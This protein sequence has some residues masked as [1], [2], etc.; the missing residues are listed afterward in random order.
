MLCFKIYCVFLK[1]EFFTQYIMFLKRLFASF[2][3]SF[4]FLFS[5]SQN[6]IQYITTAQLDS[7]YNI[8]QSKV[9]SISNFEIDRLG[10]NDC[11]LNDVETHLNLLQYYGIERFFDF[12]NLSQIE[13]Y[14]KYKNLITEVKQIRTVL[15]QQIANIDFWY[16]K[17]AK[18]YLSKSD[19]LNALLFLDKSLLYN[20]LF[21]FSVNLK[22]NLLI[23]QNKC[24]EASIDLIKISGLIYPD[25]DFYKLLYTTVLQLN[26]AL[27]EKSEMYYKT[28]YYNE[29]MLY[30]QYADSLCKSFGFYNCKD[31]TNGILNSKKGIYNSYLRIANQAIAT[32]N[33]SIAES[34]TDKALEYADINRDAI[35]NNEETNQNYR[36][37]V[38][39]YLSF[40]AKY[41]QNN[42][43]KSADYYLQKA[44]RIC[45]LL[46][47]TDCK[48][49]KIDIA[50]NILLPDTVLSEAENKHVSDIQTV[51]KEN[52]KEIKR[53]IKKR[54]KSINEKQITNIK[55]QQNLNNVRNSIALEMIEI[56]NELYSKSKF[57]EA[58]QKFSSAKTLLATAKST[59]KVKIDNLI[60]QTAE[61]I[62]ILPLKDINFAIW[63]DDFEKVDSLIKICKKLQLDYNLIDNTF[64]ND[65]LKRINDEKY[66]KICK[67]TEEKL[68][69]L[70][71]KAFSLF[72][73]KEFQKVQIIVD[74]MELIKSKSNYCSIKDGDI[75][76]I[77]ALIKPVTSYFNL[78]NEAKQS[79][80]EKKYPIFINLYNS[81]DSVY[82]L[83][84]LDSLKIAENNIIS[85]LKYQNND[86]ANMQVAEI[87]LLKG[88][89]NECFQL[90][91]VL[92]ENNYDAIQTKKI[93]EDLVELVASNKQLDLVYLNI[94]FPFLNDEK[95]FRYFVRKTKLFKKK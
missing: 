23:S 34:F 38:N 89:Q 91:N 11:E 35:S 9:K 17:T 14:Q 68:G 32:N 93:Q 55:K 26:S 20:N 84:Q 69:L 71:G 2:V 67:N 66:H 28:G 62:V 72:E 77:S 65:E 18:D 87:L 42:N 45:E 1:I 46:N 82:K 59:D 15:D 57:E 58:Y 83:Y 56:G 78:K 50:E 39:K 6:D 24:T 88:Y 27:S 43:K 3:F 75:N 48:N 22:T 49:K 12:K 4:T 19:T 44:N 90:L 36:L 81:A 63:S 51:S 5:F 10:I 76:K 47:I 29:S 37:F 52:K 79:F 92:R 8:Y 73:I 53:K 21:L 64:I 7:V 33:F 31:F 25:N 30:Y 94:K 80:D 16:Y 85:F 70:T 41:R 54:R 86:A 61:Q 95:W 60:N 74:E 13:L 40:S